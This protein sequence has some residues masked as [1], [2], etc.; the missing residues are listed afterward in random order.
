MKVESSKTGIF[1]TD[2]DFPEKYRNK[3]VEK[4]FLRYVMEKKKVKRAYISTVE[5]SEYLE[6]L[7]FEI[8]KKIPDEFNEF[9]IGEYLWAFDKLKLNDASFY[10]NR[11]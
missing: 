6:N 5:K 1:I 7:G 4:L 9:V 11:I 3:E 8:I 2:F 10:L